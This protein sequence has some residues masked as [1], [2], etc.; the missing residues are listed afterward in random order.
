M[1]SNTGLILREE[2]EDGSEHCQ[3]SLPN[4]IGLG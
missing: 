3:K 1:E 4:N 2:V